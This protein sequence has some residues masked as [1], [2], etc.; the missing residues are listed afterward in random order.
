MVEEFYSLVILGILYFFGIIIFRGFWCIFDWNECWLLCWF[1]WLDNWFIYSFVLDVSVENWFCDYL[2]CFLIFVG[3]FVINFIIVKKN[4]VYVFLFLMDL[5]G[6]SFL[7]VIWCFNWIV[8][9]FFW[10][11]IFCILIYFLIWYWYFKL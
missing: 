6:C 3:C 5:G 4:L 11:F 9:L 7:M 8:G 10:I 1:C 2:F